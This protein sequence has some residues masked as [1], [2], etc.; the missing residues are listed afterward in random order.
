MVVTQLFDGF[1]VTGCDLTF[2]RGVELPVREVRAGQQRRSCDSLQERRPDVVLCVA[3][4]SL[5]RDQLVNA[6]LFELGLLISGKARS[7]NLRKHQNKQAQP[8]SRS[9]SRQAPT[10]PRQELF[11]RWSL[12][13]YDAGLA[14]AQNAVLVRPDEASP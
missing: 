4:I 7:E 13:E 5:R 3:P 2:N 6:L 10:R 14:H 11:S 8:V 1:C 9:R 12:R